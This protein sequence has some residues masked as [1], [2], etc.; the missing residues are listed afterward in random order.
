MEKLPFKINLIYRD[1]DRKVQILS[2]DSFDETNESVIRLD[3]LYGE[4]YVYKGCLNDS[5]AHL[6]PVFLDDYDDEDLK[7]KNLFRVINTK[8]WSVFFN[9]VRGFFWFSMDAEDDVSESGRL[10][11]FA[12]QR[13]RQDGVY[14]VDIFI[15]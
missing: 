3:T 13:M 5:L 11:D 15:E 6:L 4:Y 12:F 1:K 14:V 8:H 7:N 10:G 9:P 2:F